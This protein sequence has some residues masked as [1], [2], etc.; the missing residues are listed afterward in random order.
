MTLSKNPPV[1]PDWVYIEEIIE[2][3]VEDVLFNGELPGETLRDARS[4]ISKL[5]K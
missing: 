5:R 1:D 3:A 2:N 4:K